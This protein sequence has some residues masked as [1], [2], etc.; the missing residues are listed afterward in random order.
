[1]CFN[2]KTHDFNIK[3]RHYSMTIGH[4]PK[5]EIKAP[6]EK[7]VE[8]FIQRAPDAGGAPKRIWKGQKVQIS[9]TIDPSMLDWVDEMSK[10]L[11]LSRA[12]FI[13]MAISLSRKLGV[14]FDGRDI[15]ER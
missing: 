11:G 8:A 13:Q 12:G 3:I 9:L 5:G 4:R 6:N 7:K 2:I 14:R 15:L 1:M 10:E